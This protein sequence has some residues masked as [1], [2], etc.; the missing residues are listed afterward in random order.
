VNFQ[1]PAG[2]CGELAS[3]EDHPVVLLPIH[4]RNTLRSTR[5]APAAFASGTVT[6][7]A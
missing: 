5:L 3:H 7:M 6:T 2:V 4:L 1:R